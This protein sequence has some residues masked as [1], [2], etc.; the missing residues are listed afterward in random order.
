MAVVGRINSV[1]SVVA[2]IKYARDGLDKETGEVK[3]VASGGYGIDP[4]HAEWQLK[5]TARAYGKE[6][7]VQGYSMVT[8]F[9]EGEISPQ[10]ALEVVQETWERVTAQMNGDFPCAFYVHGNTD[11]VHVHALAGA[12]DPQTGVKLHQKKMWELVKTVSDKVCKAHGLS[13]IAEKTDKRQDRVEYH[14][15][16]KGAYS[17]KSELKS[18][19]EQAL[20]PAVKGLTDFKNNLMAFGVNVHDR[21]RQGKPI[22]LYEFVGQDQKTHKIKDFK[23]GGTAYQREPLLTKIDEWGRDSLD[24][25]QKYDELSAFFKAFN[26][27]KEPELSQE[28]VFSRD[29]DDEVYWLDRDDGGM[30]L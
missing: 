19:I 12:I 6:K 1:Q 24:K 17:W 27:E 22:F 2:S 26:A 9:K 13:V 21:M 25:Q 4:N 28:D 23:L 14:L 16:Q 15:N 11:H 8:S 29:Y 20:T 7:G 3:C 10:K 5:A 30:E 18:Y